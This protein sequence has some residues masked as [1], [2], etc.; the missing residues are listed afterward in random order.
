MRFTVK[1]AIMSGLA[2]AICPAI[3]GA[4]EPGHEEDTVIG[5]TVSGQL[6]VVVNSPG[7]NELPP[8]SGLL[9]GWAADEPGLK[10]PDGD[11]PTNDFF[12][13][14][15]GA[16][17]NLQ[18]MSIDPALNV[19]SPGFVTRLNMPGNSLVIGGAEF[20]THM[21]YHIDVDDPA[22]DPGQDVYS[23]TFRLFDL[24]TTGYVPS[25]PF[26]L[27]FTPV[28][29]PATIG[30]FGVVTLGLLVNRLRSKRRARRGS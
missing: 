21:T 23:A 28:P 16:I 1:T 4:G 24:G 5:H 18:L 26:S 27:S 20:D 13:L 17:I 19:W 29:E 9:N 3:T 14:G 22:F 12:T 25:E 10:S 11:D 8:V 7:P 30:L 15:A 2:L 6:A